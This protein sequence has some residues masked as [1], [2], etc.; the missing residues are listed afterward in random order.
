MPF[1]EFGTVAN[2]QLTVS[3]TVVSLDTATAGDGNAAKLSK[4][5]IV[6]VRVNNGQPIRYTVDGGIPT[7]ALGNTTSSGFTVSGARLDQIKMIQ[8]TN[9]TGSA[10]VFVTCGTGA[11][12]L[13]QNLSI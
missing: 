7:A 11:V 2:Q 13:N 12:N 4:T 6:S 3:T 8:D 10:E 9:A 5:D 1:Q